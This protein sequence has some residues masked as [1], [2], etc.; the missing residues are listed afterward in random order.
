MAHIIQ[1]THPNIFTGL[2][3][4][5]EEY[6]VFLC[7]EKE[8]W[9]DVLDVEISYALRK[10]LFFVLFLHFIFLISF[11]GSKNTTLLKS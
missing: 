8:Y 10:S 6:K 5:S 3:F 2:D 1:C 4:T 9:N 7:D 11:L